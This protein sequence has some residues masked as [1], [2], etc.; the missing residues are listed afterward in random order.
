MGCAATVGLSACSDKEDGTPGFAE[1]FY[2]DFLAELLGDEPQKEVKT[3]PPLMNISVMNLQRADVPLYA[4]WFGQLRG[5]QQADIKP[6]VAG[7]IV[8]QDYID[9]SPCEK[10]D[11]LFHIDDETYKAAYD[12]AAANLAAAEATEAQAKIA[13]EQAQ[14]DVDRYA[15]LVGTG[16]V[17]E[18]TYIDAQHAQKRT[19]A[20]L[21]AATAH[22]LQAQAALTNAEINLKRCVITAPFKGYASAATVSVGDYVAP[23]ALSLTR[24]S[25]IN[26]I[27]VDFMVTGKHVLDIVKQTSFS[28]GNDMAAPFTSFEV[29]LEDGTVYTAKDA[30]GN[31]VPVKGKIKTMDSEVNTSTGTVSFIGEIPNEELRLRS[32]ASVQIRAEI[33]QEKDAF[34]VPKNAIL[35]SMN[36]RF[37][38]VIGKDNQ[39]Y[40]IDVILGPEALLDM[41]NGDGQV[42][43]MPMQVVMARPGENAAGES[44]TDIAEILKDLGYDNPT[45]AP[46]IAAGG[47]MAQIYAN[48]NIGMKMQGAKAGFGIVH[49]QGRVPYTYVPPV[50]T[51]PSVTAADSSSSGQ[52]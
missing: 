28:A 40:G 6:E 7:R 43:K 51:T 49:P 3:M 15:S 1:R 4:T 19:T 46:V 23:G 30:A 20:L 50:T 9:G 10:G 5:T 35:S 25:A 39:P 41:K 16:S 48:A 17:A 44:R 14:Q 2:N 37:I 32:G 27:R 29:I 36:H 42:V 13:D 22:K 24:M 12:M 26:P 47:Q 45:D 38:Y 11:P 8:S 21:A 52:K 34:V 31:D 33:G 18:K